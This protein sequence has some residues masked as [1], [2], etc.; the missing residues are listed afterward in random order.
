MKTEEKKKSFKEKWKENKELFR[1]AAEFETH[2]PA[3][4]VALSIQH[5]TKIFKIGTQR[6]KIA[7]DDVS[8]EIK[9]GQFHGF[10]G[11]NGAGKTTTIRSLLGFYPSAYGK[12]FIGPYD[13]KDKRCKKLIGYIPEAALFPKKLTVREYLYSCAEMSNI[14]RAEIKPKIEELLKKYGFDIPELDKS[15]SLMS[16][17]QKKTVLLMQA[18]LN[19]PEI[20]IMDEPAANL[21]PNARVKLYKEIKALN[22]EGKTILISSHILDELERYI[23]SCTVLSKGKLVYSG[24]IKDIPKDVS[25][26]TKFFFSDNEKISKEMTK[27]GIKNNN[28]EKYLFAQ[29]DNE[30][31]KNEILKFAIK[32]KIDILSIEKNEA[33][34]TDLYFRR[35]EKNLYKTNK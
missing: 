29:I 26:N 6:Y 21:D 23:D 14:P 20:L 22:N 16:S 2:V 30:N 35:N 4:D 10:I 11:G 8:F 34:L 32:H 24:W 3:D 33:G 7:L 18:L 9:K 13:S 1:K 25:Y 12:M 31:Q 17:G 19:D 15:A 5:L 28:S 27:L